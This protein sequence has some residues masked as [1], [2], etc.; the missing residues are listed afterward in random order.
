[1][2]R[3]SAIAPLAAA[4]LFASAALVGCATPVEQKPAPTLSSYGALSPRLKQEMTEQQVLTALATPPTKSE[5]ST[6]GQQTG[7]PWQCKTLMFG[8][9][10]NNVTV[11]FYNDKDDGN[12]RVNNWNAH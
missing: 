12:W 7:R 5:M 2:H 1:M 11:Y 8:E 9:P 3:L 6:C 10:L 4:R